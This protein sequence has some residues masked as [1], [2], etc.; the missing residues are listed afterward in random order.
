MNNKLLKSSSL[1]VLMRLI[2]RS[3][4]L[5]STLI[6]ARLLLPEDFGIIAITSLFIFFFEVLSNTGIQQYLVQKPEMDDEDVY[7]AWT[8]DIVIKGIMA[9]ICL[10]ISPLVAMFYDNPEIG[11]AVAVLSSVILIRALMNP[12]LHIF[13]RN[14]EYALIFKISVVQK[15]ISVCV[16][17]SIAFYYKSFWAIIV[18]DIVSALTGVILSYKYCHFKP[19][20]SRQ[21][22]KEQWEFSKWMLS[23]GVVGYARAQVDVFF[24]SKLFPLNQLG[25]YNMSKEIT[26]MPAFDI[27]A[28]ATEPLVATFSRVRDNLPELS[29]QF[30]LAVLVVMIFVSPICAFLFY[31]PE[32]FIKVVLGDKWI[33]A[34]PIMQVLPLLLLAFSLSSIINNVF[35]ST[36]RVKAVFYY[37]VLSLLLVV[38]ILLLMTF[39]SITD[40]ALWR[41]IV[42]LFV[43]VLFIFLAI[44]II[45]CPWH[46]ILWAMFLPMACSL[47]SIHLINLILFDNKSLLAFLLMGSMFCI[48]YFII[49]L[50]TAYIM[51]TNNLIC[52]E[53]NRNSTKFIYKRLFPGR[54]E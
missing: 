9:F 37:D 52:F 4:G 15:I 23:R 20:L 2:F 51:R 43:T 47:V 42:A 5:I 32:H 44:Y 38:S 10:V 21:R 13:R 14:L 22:F 53:I 28:P 27:I 29:K 17:I 7:S 11:Y 16:V 54:S 49:L 3:L 1:L 36:G 26:V 41:S 34:A 24:V 19:R 50:F 48:G 6:L 35:I 45:K 33:E 31:Y 8:L 39:S 12:G 30:S 40:F 25:F 18:G 46:L